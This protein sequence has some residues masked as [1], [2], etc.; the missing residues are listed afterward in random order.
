MSL[1]PP[2]TWWYLHPMP[3]QQPLTN[4]SS[5]QMGYATQHALLLQHDPK[6]MHTSS[7]P[8]TPHL[9]QQDSELDSVPCIAQNLHACQDHVQRGKFLCSFYADPCMFECTMNCCQGNREE[10]ISA[11]VICVFIKKK[12]GF[13]VSES[14]KILRINVEKLMGLS[15]SKNF[16]FGNRTDCFF[17]TDCVVIYCLWKAKNLEDFSARVQSSFPE[18]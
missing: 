2:L 1:L 17:V 10:A 16:G 15:S 4:A 18:P 8:W 14:G 5:E 3:S 13:M 6:V 9:L 11:K 12:C 7:H